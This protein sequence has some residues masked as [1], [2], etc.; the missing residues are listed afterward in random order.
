MVEEGQRCFVFFN[1]TNKPNT[2]STTKKGYA[3]PGS[4]VV[5]SDSHSNM[6][7]GVGCLGTPIVRTDAASVWATGQTWWQVPPVA[8]GIN[9]PSICKAAHLPSPF[10]KQYLLTRTI[11]KAVFT[12]N[13][14]TTTLSHTQNQQLSS[15]ENYPPV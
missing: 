12:H 6:Y 7:G 3:F 13:T 5:A 10:A 14:L 2:L 11:C 4:L 9:S 1:A 15:R 8:R